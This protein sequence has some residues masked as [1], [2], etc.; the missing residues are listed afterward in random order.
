MTETLY[1]GMAGDTDEGR[2]VSAGLYRRAGDSAWERI[3]G[4][5]DAPPEVR[6]ILTDPRRPER[7]LIGM[8]T[9]DLPAATTAAGA[10]GGFLRRRPSSRSGRSRAIRT[11]P[12]SSSPD[13]SR[14]R[15]VVAR[16][17]AKAGRESSCRRPIP[18]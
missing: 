12:T 16:T 14:P 11:T 6:A 8:R 15:S 2:F 3:D 17:T 1:A 9:R 13:T 18:P 4:P 10:G 7:V 5:F